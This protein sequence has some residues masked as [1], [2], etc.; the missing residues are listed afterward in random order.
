MKK[1]NRTVRFELIEAMD[2]GLFAKARKIANS[3]G[4]STSG[5]IRL[6]IREAVAKFSEKEVKK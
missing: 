1:S 4:Y 5:W 3:S 6:L 2:K